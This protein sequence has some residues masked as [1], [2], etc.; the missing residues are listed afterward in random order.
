MGDIAVA[1]V[2]ED[3]KL[4]TELQRNEI[5]GR[6]AA[7]ERRFVKCGRRNGTYRIENE[8]VKGNIGPSN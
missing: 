4:R 8:K 2:S 6:T 7:E 5:G 1:S 3:A